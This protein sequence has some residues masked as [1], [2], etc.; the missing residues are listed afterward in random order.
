MT[1]ALLSSILL[2]LAAAH[3]GCASATISAA[4]DSSYGSSEDTHSP[5]LRVLRYFASRGLDLFDI[6]RFGVDVGPGI[7]ADV[8]VT[9][10]L[11]MA[12]MKR[13]SAGLGFQGLRFPPAHVVSEESAILGPMREGAVLDGEP[14]YVNTWEPWYVNTWDVRAE[15][16]AAVAGAHAAVNPAEAFD[17]LLGWFTIDFMHDDLDAHDVYETGGSY[18][19]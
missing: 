3:L 13:W 17:F 6:V 16:H 14:W 12:A 18:D 10:Y 15:V 5:G 19:R 9:D 8:M 4:Q 2:F 11:R 1:R 7:G